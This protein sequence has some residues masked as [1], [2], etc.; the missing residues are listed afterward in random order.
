M[1]VVLAIISI[2]ASV[3]LPALGRAQQTAYSIK[4]INNLKM[5][6]VAISGYSNDNNSSLPTDSLY[7]TPYRVT[8]LANKSNNISSYIGISEMDNVFKNPASNPLI[9]PALASN[10]DYIN[11]YASY[12]TTEIYT[13][14][15][16]PNKFASY[17]YDSGTNGGRRCV[18]RT[19]NIFTDSAI[20]VCCK[21]IRDDSYCEP[22]SG[23]YSTYANDI[24]SRYY[25]GMFHQERIVYLRADFGAKSTFMP[26]DRDA[27]VG[28]I[29]PSSSNVSWRIK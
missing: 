6:G 7:A 10:G 28:Y 14:G 13:S 24:S 20:L 26:Y 21:P 11:W 18:A 1:L 22:I 19:T 15:L 27:N 2:L 17:T 4:C 29:T 3:L 8:L 5:T 23:L 12:T 9:C 16:I 25:A